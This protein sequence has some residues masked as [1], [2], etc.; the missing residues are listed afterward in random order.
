VA[1]RVVATSTSETAA[2]VIGTVDFT[3]YRSGGT[4]EDTTLVFFSGE[5]ALKAV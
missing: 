3:S 5:V 4:A 1:S 2:N